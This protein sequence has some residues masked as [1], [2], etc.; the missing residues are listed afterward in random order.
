ML[1]RA[2]KV[3]LR[4]GP[5]PLAW[6]WSPGT[7]AILH[8]R[9]LYACELAN[10]ATTTNGMGRRS[11]HRRHRLARRSRS[12]IA[13]GIAQLARE[14]VAEAAQVDRELVSTG[15]LA[16]GNQKAQSL[17][18]LEQKVRGVEDAAARVCK[19]AARR[20]QLARTADPAQLSLS[21]RISV[22]EAAIGELS[23]GPPS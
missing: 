17:S 13:D 16:H 19:L 4:S 14:V 10:A 22:V 21:E 12:P 5:V 18:V 9:L 15:R 11:H 23:P 7:A 6:L 20:A 3:A 2:N 1:R 8:R